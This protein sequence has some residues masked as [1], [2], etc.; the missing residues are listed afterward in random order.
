MSIQPS[1]EGDFEATFNT[2]AVAADDGV[3][4]GRSFRVPRRTAYHAAWP[5]DLAM[6][7]AG[8]PDEAPNLNVL[9]R[10]DSLLSFDQDGR[11]VADRIDAKDADDFRSILDLLSQ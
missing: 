9:K 3:V 11:I 8:P 7:Y 6:G 5:D 10:G 4:V 2:L 1:D